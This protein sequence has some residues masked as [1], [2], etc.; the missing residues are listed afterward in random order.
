VEIIVRPP[1]AAGTHSAASRQALVMTP[2]AI[3]LMAGLDAALVL[4]DL[5]APVRWDRLPEVHGALMVFGFVG[6]LIALERAVAL[7]RR[8]ALVAPAGFGV[9]GLAL[10]SPLDLHVGKALLVTGGVGLVVVYRWLWLRQPSEALLLQAGGAVAATGGTVLWLGGVDVP[11]LLPWTVAFVVLTIAGERLEL[12]RV[13][14]LSA[15]RIGALVATGGLLLVA[16]PVALLWPDVGAPVAGIALM[17][18][19]GWLVGNDVARRMVRTCGPARFMAA[20]LLAG[21]AW[22]AVAGGIWLLTGPAVDGPRYDAVVHAV[23][24]GFTMSMIMA[25][26]P[27]LLPAVLRRPLP[28]HSLLWAPAALLQ[29]SVRVRVGVGDARPLTVGW[30]LGGALGVVA[31][32]LFIGVAARLVIARTGRP[33]SADSTGRR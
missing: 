9:G 31:V 1:A 33:V 4:L 22:L 25:H 24:L 15:G 18:L 23:F 28:Y 11:V 19:V 14:L 8:W 2:A 12:A 27:V 29:A 5:P 6:T 10:L 32:L 30:R 7:G 13:V 16:A 21:Y 26:A 3:C 20:C 17:L